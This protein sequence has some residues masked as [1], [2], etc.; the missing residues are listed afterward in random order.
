M[1]DGGQA[2]KEVGVA[3]SADRQAPVNLVHLGGLSGG[4]WG[5][6]RGQGLVEYALILVTVS[7]AVIVAMTFYREQL[8]ELFST[9]GN[10]LT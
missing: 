1:A 8:G 5:D 10:N 6:Q 3:H 2:K 4:F 7:I 9:I